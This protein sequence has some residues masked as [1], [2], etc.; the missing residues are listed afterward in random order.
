MCLY[1]FED[2][3][4][5]LLMGD[6]L[7]NILIDIFGKIKFFNFVWNFFF[8]RIRF[9]V[10]KYVLDCI[11]DNDFFIFVNSL[12]LLVLY[13]VWVLVVNFILKYILV[14]WLDDCCRGWLFL[15]LVML[16]VFKIV[17]VVFVF[18]IRY[19]FFFCCIFFECWFD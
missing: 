10:W 4:I 18:L 19:M 3:W 5:V 17:I 6:R 16:G 7:E 2:D 9:D 12:Y 15:L 8:G 11:V 13:D 14:D 1:F